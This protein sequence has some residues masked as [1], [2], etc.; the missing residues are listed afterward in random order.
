MRN[1]CLSQHLLPAITLY[2]TQQN[3]ECVHIRSQQH[4]K[5][6]ISN[7]WSRQS[8]GRK[9]RFLV[10]WDMTLKLILITKSQAPRSNQTSKRYV[11]EKNLTHGRE[12][13]TISKFSAL[14]FETY[15]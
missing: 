7:F 8:F 12:S 5:F 3:W 13:L 4:T 14:I 10:P 15:F 6:H 11:N 2:L 1:L 9:P